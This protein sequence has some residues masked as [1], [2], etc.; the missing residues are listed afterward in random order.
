VKIRLL[1]FESELLVKSKSC[2]ASV[3]YLVQKYFYIDLK[4]IA[5]RNLMNEMLNG[6]CC[7]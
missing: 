7:L 6:K 3:Q 4:K 5:L 2:L 1:N